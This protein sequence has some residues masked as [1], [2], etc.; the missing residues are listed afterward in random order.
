VPP[1]AQNWDDVLHRQL[2]TLAAV[3]AGM[4]LAFTQT[5]KIPVG[6]WERLDPRERIAAAVL[7]Q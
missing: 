5:G 4:T 2:S 1:S 6:N 3:A 7:V